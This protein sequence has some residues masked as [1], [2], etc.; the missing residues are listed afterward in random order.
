[1]TQRRPDFKLVVGLGNPGGEYTETR[2]NAG[3]WLVER[4]ADHFGVHFSPDSKSAGELA[5]VQRGP[6]DMRLLKPTTFMNRSGESV[7]AVCQYFKIDPAEL[8]VVHDEL[9]L[10]PGAVKVKQAGGHGG[11]NGLRDIARVIGNNYWRLRVGIGHPGHRDRVSPWVLS[12]PSRADGE[13]IE[14]AADRV[15]GSLDGLL[16]GDFAKA[17]QAINTAPQV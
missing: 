14:A 5:R 7:L 4:I 10:P 11:H 16:V 13:L 17:T 8:L 9:D 2:H 3:F 12:R 6:L 15:M 1:M